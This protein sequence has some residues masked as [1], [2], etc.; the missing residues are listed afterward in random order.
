VSESDIKN[1]DALN[2]KASSTK[3]SHSTI[4]P[5][6]YRLKNFDL[7]F[8][9]EPLD[10]I[11]AHGSLNEE[12]VQRAIEWLDPKYDDDILDL[13][14]GLGNF[15][16]PIAKKCQSVT[17]VEGSSAMT[18][19][20][21]KNA[22]LNNIANTQFFEADLEKDQALSPWINKHYDAILLDPPRSGASNI[23]NH[24]IQTD[25]KRIVYVSCN[26]KT[27]A[28]DALKLTNFGFKLDK[29][30]VAD[31]FPHTEH[32]ETVGLFLKSDS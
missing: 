30:C 17:G 24:M 32:I 13:F 16:L 7:T 29:I 12:L 31:M 1:T 20:A 6:L 26:P 9:F 19:R 25:P 2:L 10:F 15:S 5:L 28:Q 21:A 23:I 11:Q 22:A 8:H 4:H 27:F 3:E 18:Q 14:C